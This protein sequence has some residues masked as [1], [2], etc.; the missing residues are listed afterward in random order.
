MGKF[1]TRQNGEKITDENAGEDTGFAPWE[2][3]LRPVQTNSSNIPT[4]FTI[5]IVMLG[6]N[7]LADL[8]FC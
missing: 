5:I 8:D 7:R 2:S 3:G 1:T 4:D 6:Y